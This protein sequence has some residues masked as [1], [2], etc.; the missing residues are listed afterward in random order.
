[1]GEDSERENDPIGPSRASRVR[2]WLMRPRTVRVVGPA[3]MLLGVALVVIGLLVVSSGGGDE[4]GP[5]AGPPGVEP[6]PGAVPGTAYPV[7][8]EVVQAW[9]YLVPPVQP[10]ADF[11]LVIDS[12]GVDAEVVELGLDPHRTPQVPDDGVTVAWYEFTAEPGTGS[13]AVMSGHV[14]WAGDPGVFA[15]LD[16]LEEGDVIRVKWKDGKESD[17]NVSTNRLL[18]ADSSAVLQ[19]ME[20]TK[21]DTITLITCG[22]TWKTDANKP[23]GGDF[24]H[25]V[26]VQAR[27]ADSS[28]TALSP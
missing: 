22:G 19:A 10:S 27:L 28:A 1:M 20:P 17:Y 6:G 14:R 3:A 16:E 24:S 13:N 26:V 21:K 7:P 5:A 8:P 23:L 11:R 12:L 4:A 15:D 2:E 9:R 25:R 18:R